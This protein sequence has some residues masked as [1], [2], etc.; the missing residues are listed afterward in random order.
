MHKGKTRSV[1]E[2]VDEVPVTLYPVLGEL[3]I[4]SLGRKGCQREPE[5]IRAILVNYVKGINHVSL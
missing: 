4:A 5:R 3:D 2:F 1:P